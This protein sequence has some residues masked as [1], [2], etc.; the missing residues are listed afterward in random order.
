M[1]NDRYVKYEEAEIHR[2]A[3]MQNVRDKKNIFFLK[4]W[5]TGSH[6][7]F[8]SVKFVMGY[9]CVRHYILF[10]IH[11]PVSLHFLS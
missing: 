4:K 7:P 1:V 8:F 6:F 10:Y 9:P 2:S 5:P 11:G 3:I